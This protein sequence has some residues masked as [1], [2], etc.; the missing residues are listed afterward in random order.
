MRG[1]KI[2]SL[3]AC[4]NTDSIFRYLWG[5]KANHRLSNHNCFELMSAS[6]APLA[7]AAGTDPAPGSRRTVV[8]KDLVPDLSLSLF[9][10]GIICST[11]ADH[12][13]EKYNLT[14]KAYR[15]P[16]GDKSKTSIC[17]KYIYIYIY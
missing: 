2:I 8:D 5:R 6:A 17:T 1:F 7:A 11:N 16:A 4:L 14:I 3:N 15:S 13:S 9:M 10:P 12:S